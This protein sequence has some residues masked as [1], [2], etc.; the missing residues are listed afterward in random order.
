MLSKRVV[1][2]KIFIFFIFSSIVLSNDFFE[3]LK[4]LEN[5]VSCQN[6]YNIKQKQKQSKKNLQEYLICIDNRVQYSEDKII[7]EQSI[8]VIQIFLTSNKRKAKKI[9]AQYNFD[10]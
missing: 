10:K 3:R 9:V 5:K 1:M 4:V 7:N 8:E 2:K 6:Q